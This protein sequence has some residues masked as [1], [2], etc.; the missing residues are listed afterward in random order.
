MTGSPQIWSFLRFLAVGGSFSLGYSVVTAALIRFA[1]APPF[2]T[3]VII[4]LLCIPAAFWAQ[5]KIAFR[6]DQ[7]GRGAMLIYAA[8]QVG[9]LAIVSTVT[10]RLLTKNF[11]IDT[12]ILLM[13]AGSAAVISYLICRFII[14]RSPP[15]PSV[16]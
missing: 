14:F 8:T 9:S 10:T 1:G 16:R 4:Y 5:R 12:L 2:A 11:V 15:G 6:A 13:T 3:S 7:T